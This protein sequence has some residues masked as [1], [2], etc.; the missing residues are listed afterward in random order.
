MTRDMGRVLRMGRQQV[1][2][3]LR[4][5]IGAVDRDKRIEISTEKRGGIL[6]RNILTTASD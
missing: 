5:Y 4:G 1:L 6:E 3:M 2:L